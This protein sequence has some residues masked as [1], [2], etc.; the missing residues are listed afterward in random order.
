MSRKLCFLLFVPILII[1]LASA[2]SAQA[3]PPVATEAWAHTWGGNGNDELYGVAVD[4][5]GNLW[6]TGQTASFGS[7]GLD[8]LLLKYSPSGTL[9]CRQTWGGSGND[10]GRDVAVNLSNGSVYVA[11]LR[12][13]MILSLRDW[14]KRIRTERL[15]LAREA[16]LA[17]RRRECVRKT[18]SCWKASRLLRGST[19]PRQQGRSNPASTPSCELRSLWKARPAAR[20]STSGSTGRS[21]EERTKGGWRNKK[22]RPCQGRSFPLQGVDKRQTWLSVGGSHT[23]L[24]Q[25]APEV[26]VHEKIGWSSFSYSP[27][28]D[29][30]KRSILGSPH[31]AQGG[32]RSSPSA[33]SRA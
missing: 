13:R 26:A 14:K 8:V 15:L 30:R 31:K 5:S 2:V 10:Y 1:V 22:A 32:R 18:Q 23:L 3:P 27:L 9:L 7:G 4:G 29:W 25:F 19:K 21:D 11:G 12:V 33:D 20:Y 28:L 24:K 17:A 6:V 16:L